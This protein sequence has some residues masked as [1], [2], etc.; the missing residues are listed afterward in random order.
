ME[1]QVI[2]DLFKEH[3]D[4]AVPSLMQKYEKLCNTLSFDILQ[5]EEATQECVKD[6]FDKV[7]QSIAEKKADELPT[8]LCKVTREMAL[9]RYKINQKNVKNPIFLVIASE[10]GSWTRNLRNVEDRLTVNEMAECINEAL[11]MMEEEERA[12]FMQ[13]YWFCKS[14]DDLQVALGMSMKKIGRYLDQ[15]MEKIR[16]CLAERGYQ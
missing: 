9:D 11:G 5:D 10:M 8:Y 16:K 14:Y 15:S 6:I 2:I 12:V 1:D 4:K 3:S 13:R 7:Q